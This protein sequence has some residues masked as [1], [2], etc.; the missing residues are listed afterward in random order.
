MGLLCMAGMHTAHYQ[1]V[2]MDWQCVCLWFRRVHS[3]VRAVNSSFKLCQVFETL[4]CQQV[5][6][7]MGGACCHTH[8][9]NH[10]HTCMVLAII[11]VCI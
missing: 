9:H 6:L 10:T 8:T 5:R 7:M 11:I 4:V 1:S 3:G 2:T